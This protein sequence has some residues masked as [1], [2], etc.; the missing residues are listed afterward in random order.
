MIDVRQLT[1]GA[2]Q[3]AAENNPSFSRPLARRVALEATPESNIHEISRKAT[4]SPMNQPA[5]IWE[6]RSLSP[7]S[8][9]V[10][11]ST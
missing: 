4:Q 7:K 1:H 3:L 2:A 6:L 8:L 9:H 11:P 10:N 5:S